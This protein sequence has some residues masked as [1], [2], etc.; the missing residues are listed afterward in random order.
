MAINPFVSKARNS[1][2]MTCSRCQVNTVKRYGDLHAHMAK[3]ATDYLHIF[4]EYKDGLLNELHLLAAVTA[5]VA[6]SI[7]KKSNTDLNTMTVN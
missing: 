6:I 2:Y 7:A 4:T 5:Y 1:Q 3:C